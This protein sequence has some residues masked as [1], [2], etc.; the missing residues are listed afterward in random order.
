LR[1][2]SKFERSLGRSVIENVLKSFAKE[3][4]PN[5]ELR[6]NSSF[7]LA[8]GTFVDFFAAADVVD[9]VD[10]NVDV[11][12]VND[13]PVWASATFSSIEKN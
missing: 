5:L 2:S 10:V 8:S 6:L 4:S 13:V 7:F 9:V 1:R 3:R 11:I 12:D